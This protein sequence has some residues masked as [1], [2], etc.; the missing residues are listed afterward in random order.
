[1]NNQ[2]VKGAA[3]NAGGGNIT[4]NIYNIDGNGANPTPTPQVASGGAVETPQVD[5]LEENTQMDRTQWLTIFLLG[6][7]VVSLVMNIIASRKQIMILG[8]DNTQLRKDL[9]ELMSW[10]E[11]V[12]SKKTK[13]Q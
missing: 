10:K 8:Q 2:A 9:D 3:V 12:L 5:T 7:T 13:N 6:L 11:S 4:P 1:M